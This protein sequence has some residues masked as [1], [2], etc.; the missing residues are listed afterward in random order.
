MRDGRRAVWQ[1]AERGR[2]TDRPWGQSIK[3]YAMRYWEWLFWAIPQ[4][5]Q[6]RVAAPLK[7]SIHEG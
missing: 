4:E 6:S 7:A 1:Q 2:A 5:P 3:K